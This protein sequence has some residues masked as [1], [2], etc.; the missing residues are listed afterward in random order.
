MLWTSLC[1]REFENPQ[2]VIAICRKRAIDERIVILK[3]MAEAE[4]PAGVI[5]EFKPGHQPAVDAGC[6]AACNDSLSLL[7]GE[8]EIIDI[9]RLRD[10]AVDSAIQLH[11]LCLRHVVIWLFFL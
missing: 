10:A 4:L 3:V 1:V 6:H 5:E 7:S 2:Q 9:G 11:A 8:Q